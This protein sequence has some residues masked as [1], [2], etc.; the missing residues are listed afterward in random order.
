MGRTIVE[1]LGNI[2][3]LNNAATRGWIL[4][5]LLLLHSFLLLVLGKNLP[6]TDESRKAPSRLFR[7]GGPYFHALLCALCA[8]CVLCGG[9]ATKEEEGTIQYESYLP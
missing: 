2:G 6:K 4:V 3:L 5:V 7:C 1:L 9:A 8:C